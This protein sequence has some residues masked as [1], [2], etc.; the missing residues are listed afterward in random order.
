MQIV[1]GIPAAASLSLV[2][3]FIH[4]GFSSIQSVETD[5]TLHRSAR[6]VAPLD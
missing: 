1:D 5:T 3:G 4:C 6:P 2:D